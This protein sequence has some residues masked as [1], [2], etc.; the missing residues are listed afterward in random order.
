MG[1]RSFAE[2]TPALMYL[3]K[4]PGEPFIPLT[5]HTL[6]IGQTLLGTYYVPGIEFSAE[7]TN[8]LK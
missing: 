2:S 8:A 7:G 4:D 5:L 1:Q 6:F 3:T